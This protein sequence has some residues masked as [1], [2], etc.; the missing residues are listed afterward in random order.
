M[1]I[2]TSGSFSGER[3][4]GLVD[5]VDQLTLSFGPVSSGLVDELVFATQIAG[6]N[7][8]GTGDSG[9]PVFSYRVDLR[10]IRARG[11]LSGA[12][13]LDSISGIDFRA[14]CTGDIGPGR[15]CSR[16]LSYS[17]IQ[18]SMSHHDVWIED[19]VGP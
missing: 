1:L 9:G 5:S 18:N 16:R 17:T 12:S 13:L 8:G 11:I 14:P 3:C 7:L 6:E 4:D 15:I 2:C 10:H 19:G